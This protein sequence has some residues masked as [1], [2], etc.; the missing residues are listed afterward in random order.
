MAEDEGLASS[1]VGEDCARI[2]IPAFSSSLVIPLLNV[3]L[4]SMIGDGTGEV[5][6][7][8]LRV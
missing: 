1:R 8:P 7:V 4:P 6:S 3:P 2:V 5:E